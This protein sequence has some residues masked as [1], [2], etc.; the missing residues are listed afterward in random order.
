LN[1]AAPPPPDV[2]IAR[3]AMATRFEMALH[4]SRPE[5]LRAAAE[6]ALDEIERLEAQLSIYRPGSEMT[7]LNASAADG[8]V[9]VEPRLFR[10]LQRA[11]EISAATEGAFDITTAPLIRAWGFMGGSGH[12]PEPSELA[13]ARACVGWSLVELDEAALT[14]RF[15]RP[16]VMLDL[17]A[18]GKGFA[19]DCAVEVLRECGVENALIHGGTS[20]VCGLGTP[21]GLDAW[22]VALPEP[23]GGNDGGEPTIISLRDES[24][25]VSGVWGKSFTEGGRTYGHVLDPRLGEP[26]AGAQMAAVVL[27]SATES[28]ALSTALLVLGSAGIDPVKRYRSEARVWVR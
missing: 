13:A 7:R 5:S 14:V 26:V 28:D 10:L 27:P 24:L 3:H 6:S 21:P 20:T 4:G 18:V 17:G 16:G 9:R 15:V 8:P 12:T 23:A 1:F 11:R 19:L 2:I 22:R 25:S